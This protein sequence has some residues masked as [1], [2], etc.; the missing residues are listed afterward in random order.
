MGDHLKQLTRPYDTWVLGAT[1]TLLLAC[2]ASAQEFHAPAPEAVTAQ[3]A[4]AAAALDQAA[5]TAFSSSVRF[6]PIAVDKF[7]QHPDP[8]LEAQLRW[9]F[10]GLT[11]QAR[12]SAHEAAR[13]AL[14][15]VS[16]AQTASGSSAILLPAN[17]RR[18]AQWVE[19]QAPPGKDAVAF[20]KDFVTL[21]L[22]HEAARAFVEQRYELTKRW[23]ACQSLEQYEVLQALADGRALWLTRAVS[24]DLGLEACFPLLTDR[25]E[26][27]LLRPAQPRLDGAAPRKEIS[28]SELYTLCW[29]TLKER[30]RLALIGLGYID[31]LEKQGGA[32]AVDRA[33]ASPP[34]KLAVMEDAGAGD[35][36]NGPR[37]LPAALERVQALLEPPDFWRCTVQP[38]S[39]ALVR[40]VAD[41][42]GAK[43][44]AERVLA[45][46]QEG[47]ALVCVPR[48]NVDAQVAIGVVRLADAPGARAYFGVSAE[49][50]RRQDELLN[51]KPNSPQRVAKSQAQAVQ[52][53]GA[54][55][56]V[57][58]DKQ[59]VDAHGGA[60][61]A[62][63]TT[64]LARTG[65]LVVL[66]TWRG[67]QPDLDWAGQFLGDL[68]V[69]LQK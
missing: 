45:S 31:R 26:C 52:L 30:H 66:F 25:L 29:L 10:P 38:W 40:D 15:V 39:P 41:S 43:E 28:E 27:V 2:P 65:D 32:A 34:A 1:L 53:V 61:T 67:I 64:V 48:E 6:V 36:G 20:R 17:T 58:T 60:Q 56:A 11:G 50:Q 4:R 19:H 3:F 44:Q 57:R 21:A 23:P 7:R 47:A 69:E 46:W 63:V 49:L 55:E 5:G 35:T 42:L 59:F 33:F 68:M 62:A 12:K 54:D 9:H 13:D 24:H 18:L 51:T 22:A 14:R 16:V 8:H 37:K